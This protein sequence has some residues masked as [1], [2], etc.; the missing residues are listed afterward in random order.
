MSGKAN[1]ISLPAIVLSNEIFFVN[2]RVLIE[3]A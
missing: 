1:E 3:N 2:L